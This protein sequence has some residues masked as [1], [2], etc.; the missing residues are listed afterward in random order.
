MSPELPPYRGDYT[1]DSTDPSE[2]KQVISI[3]ETQL[4]ETIDRAEELQKALDEATAQYQSAATAQAA[5]EARAEALSEVVEAR[6]RDLDQ[7]R[8]TLEQREAQHLEE[9]AR[10]RDEAESRLTETVKRA[11]E[12]QAVDQERA[13]EQ[14][15]SERDQLQETV[16]SLQDQI[17]AGAEERVTEPTSLAERFAEA[18]AALA[19]RPPA[20]G[21]TVEV[22]LAGLQVEAR[23]VLRAPA[24]EGD[25]PEFV[26]TAPGAVDPGQLSTMR[27]EFRLSPR[28]PP[29]TEES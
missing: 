28:I 22:N 12:E 11:L 17:E 16:K 13:L 26:T 10:L 23:G 21:Q 29:Q 9:I 5:A 14:L 4:L 27:M 25:P 18:V 6:T 2:L 8:G 3:R 24:K 7:L 19:E 1:V 15:R 20:A